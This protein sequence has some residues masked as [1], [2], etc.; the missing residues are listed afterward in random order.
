MAKIWPVYGE[1]QY[2]SWGELPWLQCLEVFKLDPMRRIEECPTFNGS[3]RT[4]VY[5][6]A[7]V[8]QLEGSEA[9]HYGM[10]SGF[11]VS[12]LDGMTARLKLDEVQDELE[13]ELQA[14]I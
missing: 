2:G 10:K 4:A 3:S 12:P 14:W 6:D 5:P 1:N 11:F 7:V 8:V 13:D 9:R